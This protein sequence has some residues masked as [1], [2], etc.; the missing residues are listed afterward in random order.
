MSSLTKMS[1][2]D[3]RHLFCLADGRQTPANLDA[4]LGEKFTHSNIRKR[5]PELVEKGYVQKVGPAEQSGL[6]EITVEGMVAGQHAHTYVIGYDDEFHN[7]VQRTVAIQDI[8]NATDADSLYIVLERYERELLEVLRDIALGSGA[9]PTNV[10]S[11]YKEEW[12]GSYPGE[13][14]AM[15]T[16]SALYTLSFYG[17]AERTQGVDLYRCTDLGT[18]VSDQVPVEETLSGVSLR[19]YL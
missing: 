17:C 8:Q 7:L 4:L 2:L 3:F 11:Y 5:L 15:Q 13:L 16:A 9:S 19:D 12:N 10:H 18:L 1:D 14:S 6:Y